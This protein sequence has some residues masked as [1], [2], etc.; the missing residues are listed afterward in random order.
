MLLAVAGALGVGW[1]VVWFLLGRHVRRQAALA[2]RIEEL[3]SRGRVDPAGTCR[4]INVCVRIARYPGVIRRE[5][6]LLHP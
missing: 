6:I 3:E 1:L 2:K 4:Q 5:R